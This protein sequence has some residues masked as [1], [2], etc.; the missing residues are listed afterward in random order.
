[1][2]LSLSLR[3]AARGLRRRPGISL[4]AV[5]ALGFGVGLPTAV[6]S[7]VDA[8]VLRGLPIPE[9]GRLMHLERRRIGA[10]GEGFGAAPR[11]YA[12]WS[13]QARSFESLAAFRTATVTVRGTDGADRF[14][15]AYVTPNGFRV[16]GV[17]PALGR[18][19]G[20]SDTPAALATVVV[21][22]HRVWRDR[23]GADPALV[24]R[25]LWVEG[26]PRTV[27]GVMPPSFRFPTDEELW[28]PLVLPAGLA[29][30][31][32]MDVFGLLRRGVTR[33]AARA[34]LAVVARRVAQAYPATNRGVEVTVKPFT[35]RFIGE[36]ATATLYVMLGMVL[37][38]LVVACTN[39]ASLLLVRAV[40]RAR[41][42]VVGVALGASRAR[43]VGDVLLESTLLAAAGVAL[44]VGVAWGGVTLLA[45]AFAG[46]LPYW[47][48]PRVD[49]RVAAFAVMLGGAAA[50]LAGLL[51]ALRATRADPAGVLRDDTR[52]A[53]G[54]R[55]GRVMQ[56]L[57]VVE[58][59]LSMALLVT[60]ALLTRSVVNSGR[61]DVG[62]PTRDLFT[63]RVAPP[64]GTSADA[65]TRFYEELERRVRQLPAVRGAGLVSDL[66]GTHAPGG[67]VAVEGAAYRT[68][69]EMP[70]ARVASA[71]ATLFDALGVAP[72]SG[73]TFVAQDVA[74]GAPVAVVNARFAHR[75]LRGEPV[76]QRIRVG[77]DTAAW[78]T[79]VGVVPDLWMGAFD[80]SP[81]RNP[82][83]VYVPLAQVPP[84]GVAVAARVRGGSPLALTDAVRAAVFA[85]DRDAPI[86]DVR[87][88][89]G[90]V[91]DGTWF[92]G[93]G[94]GIVGVCGVAALL[95]AAVGVYGVVA[96]SVGQRR[97]EFGIRVA[98]GAAPGS[99]VRLVLRRGAGQLALGLG[100]GAALA[101]ALA[102]GVASLLFQVSPSDPPVFAGIAL[103]LAAI[104]AAA[105]LVPARSA[106][107]AEP[108]E[109][110]SPR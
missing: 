100:V 94:A 74:R 70:V 3:R 7:L 42:I 33:D 28:I 72:V 79:I 97:R 61:V 41:E 25:T 14:R 8:A 21:L 55:V 82:A 16:L 40:H 54:T 6:F 60:A 109:T 110:L 49:A 67:R 108:L 51:P 95:F 69:D 68:R 12:E 76:G 4:L 18:A 92:Y 98:L 104:G 29:D 17:A 90:V 58:L 101:A 87:D 19:F 77:G 9:R 36:T 1:M 48:E 63:A 31:E 26:A 81:D 5:L 65:R 2:S 107:R 103:G 93:L 105:M 89:R 34:E 53:T 30:G 44:G 86:Y 83:G 22:G 43:V 20:P 80:A 46:R 24:G 10:S 64:E 38:V 62:F 52:G 11:D 99:I 47:A 50:V 88:M 102:Q 39:V 78:R 96:F 23:Y 71:S 66:P 32:P 27:I 85:V 56:S 13:A 73:R 75:Y 35:E 45:R 91:A 15:A 57:V 84:T 59:A 37:L 106:A